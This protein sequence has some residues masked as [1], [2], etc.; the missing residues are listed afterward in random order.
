MSY[1]KKI[2]TEKNRQQEEIDSKE[3]IEKRCKKEQ[4]IELSTRLLE[5][6]MIH[7]RGSRNRKK[8]T[9]E[10]KWKSEHRC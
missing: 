3:Q 7:V 10:E 2:R 9:K 4:N 8:W 5:I 6:R 1:K